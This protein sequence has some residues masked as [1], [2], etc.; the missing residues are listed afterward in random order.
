M[1][2]VNNKGVVSVISAFKQWKQ[3]YIDKMKFFYK[4]YP[5]HTCTVLFI[6]LF[7]V[8]VMSHLLACS[9]AACR[10]FHYIRVTNAYYVFNLWLV[11]TVYVHTYICTYARMYIHTYIHTYNTYIHIYKQHIHIQTYNINAYTSNIHT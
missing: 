9:K 10:I 4:A 11:C 2:Q 1:F 7:C 8:L 5:F 6:I 3:G